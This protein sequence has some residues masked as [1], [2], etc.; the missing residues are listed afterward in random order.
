MKNLEALLEKSLYEIK[1]LHEKLFY[2]EVAIDLFHEKIN[3]SYSKSDLLKIYEEKIEELR[4]EYFESE[5]LYENV[6]NWIKLTRDFSV[7]SEQTKDP[8]R[9]KT[10]GFNGA[11][12]EKSRREFKFQ[13]KKLEEEIKK[14]CDDY[15]ARNSGKIFLIKGYEYSLFFDKSRETQKK[16]AKKE[17]DVITK[18]LI[19]LSSRNQI[20]NNCQ[21]R[22]RL[23][24]LNN[25][26]FS[27]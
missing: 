24:S 23:T 15:S 2:S 1:V 3:K 17:N 13:F 19:N 26:Q 21:N 12:E 25:R 27:K 18:R 16:T 5:I 14:N 22:E 8:N 9:F 11:E 4:F 6:A 20:T 7:F 10:R